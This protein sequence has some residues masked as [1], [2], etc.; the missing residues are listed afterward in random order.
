MRLSRRSIFLCIPLVLL[1]IGLVAFVIVSSWSADEG[2]LISAFRQNL[3][4][5]NY[6]ALYED[7]SS[8]LRKV[9][10]RTE[11]EQRMGEIRTFLIKKDR[12]LRF[13]R[14]VEKERN[15][16]AV[17]DEADRQM[18][19]E[20]FSIARSETKSAFLLIGSPEDPVAS[21]QVTWVEE[22]LERKIW[23]VSVSSS[24]TLDDY[25]GIRSQIVSLK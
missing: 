10:N 24:R 14:D 18:E 5:E 6:T 20:G 21:M 23:D 4:D 15:L 9:V 7:S 22:G 19:A 17:F 12:N 11:F 1:A 8:S 2:R 16:N 25:L 3:I 13:T